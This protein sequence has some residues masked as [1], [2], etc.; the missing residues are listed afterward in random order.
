M[1]NKDNSLKKITPGRHSGRQMGG[2]QDTQSP[3]SLAAQGV[4]AGR[5][6]VAIGDLWNIPAPLQNAVISF[7]LC[8]KFRRGPCWPLCSPVWA[9]RR[10]DRTR[11]QP[12]SCSQ[13][14]ASVG[15]VSPRPL[16]QQNQLSVREQQR[17]NSPAGKPA[18]LRL[19]LNEKIRLQEALF[20]S[21]M[22]QAFT[23]KQA[24][25]F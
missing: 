5:H 22:G 3:Q 17:R 19:C 21:P 15:A 20:S 7:G 4:E 23:P 24:V 1:E 13:R 2:N 12:R 16:P 18:G 10:W 11:T 6:W 9:G 25:R 8:K 14:G